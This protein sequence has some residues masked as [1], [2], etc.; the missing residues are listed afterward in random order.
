M[1]SFLKAYQK[2]NISFWGLTAQNEP[3]DGYIYNHPFQAMGFLPALQR[4]FIKLDL[5]P[6]L[7]ASN[8]SHVKLMILDD[9]RLLL[10]Y[11]ANKVLTCLLTQIIVFAL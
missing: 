8:H 5:G 7:H 6:A 10:P 1:C 11:W 3:T 4:D 2:H 9:N